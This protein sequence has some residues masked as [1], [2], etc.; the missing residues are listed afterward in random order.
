[1]HFQKQIQFSKHIKAG[2]HLKEFNFLKLNNEASPTYY[3]D[4]SDERGRRHQFL[5]S[6]DGSQWKILGE[7][8]PVWITQAESLLVDAVNNEPV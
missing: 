3:V 5:L 7:G 4:V 8:I 6:N 1:M 2:G